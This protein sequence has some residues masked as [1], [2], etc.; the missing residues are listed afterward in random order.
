MRID[1]LPKTVGRRT[2]AVSFNDLPKITRITPEWSI[3]HG[4]SRLNITG[5]K[6]LDIIDQAEIR[7]KDNRDKVGKCYREAGDL[8]CESPP[9][10]SI[11]ESDKNLRSA[12]SPKKHAVE[13]LYLGNALN[14][15]ASNP[16]TLEYRPPP[17]V[18]RQD[19][20]DFAV[21]MKIGG[22]GFCFGD[23]IEGNDQRR[24]RVRF[25]VENYSNLK[26]I[27]SFL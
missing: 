22:S 24:C 14:F 9:S 13:F 26:N 19:D 2:Y 1:N 27:R 21:I 20:Q 25:M 18:T 23:V 17:Q 7:L 11:S 3:I 16:I 8:I 4:G 5:G 15:E 6:D 12:L 10:P